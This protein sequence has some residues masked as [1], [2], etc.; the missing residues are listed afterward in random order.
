MHEIS[1]KINIFYTLIRASAYQEVRNTSFS[2]N[3]VYE[4]NGN[5]IFLTLYSFVKTNKL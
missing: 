3:F 4:S 1:Q 2:K 5:A